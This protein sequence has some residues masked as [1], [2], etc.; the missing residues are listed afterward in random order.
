MAARDGAG[1]LRAVL[2]DRVEVEE[3][4]V[5]DEHEKAPGSILEAFDEVTDSRQKLR[6]RAEIA[7]PLEG[8]GFRLLG[9]Q[10][11]DD[12]DVFAVRPDGP[13]DASGAM[14]GVD[15]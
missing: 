2:L 1:Q 3:L 14:V 13:V 5:G 7:R 9:R 10:I 8:I 12:F 6:A 4:A 15:L 11:A